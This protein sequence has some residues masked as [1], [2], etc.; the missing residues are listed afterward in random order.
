RETHHPGNGF[1]KLARRLKSGYKL[2]I[3]KD[4][5]SEESLRG[6]NL[7]VFGSPRERFLQEE[8]E[9]VKSYLRSG[10]SAVFLLGE[11][12]EERLGTN[13]NYL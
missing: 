12:G 11:G 3:N 6:V 8:F 5:L 10:G 4:E 2:Q 1:K 9:A 13:V 7:I